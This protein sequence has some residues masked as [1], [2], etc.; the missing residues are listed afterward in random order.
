MPQEAVTDAWPQDALLQDDAFE[1]AKE[2]E[3]L[4]GQILSTARYL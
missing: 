4:R 1:Q 3:K 2:K